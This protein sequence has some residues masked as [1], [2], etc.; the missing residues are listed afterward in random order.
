MLPLLGILFLVLDYPKMTLSNHRAAAKVAHGKIICLPFIWW[1]SKHIPK[2]ESLISGSR[3]YTA[4]IWTL[5]HV[6]DPGSMPL[7]LLNLRHRRILPQYQL[8]LA[9]AMTG[10]NLPLM[11]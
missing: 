8:I 5:I 9:K 11:L 10:A 2:P 1:A 7:E 4:A 3:Y 6:K